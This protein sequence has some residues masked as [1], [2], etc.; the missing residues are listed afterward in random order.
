MTQLLTAAL[1][2]V[3]PSSLGAILA[4]VTLATLVGVHEIDPAKWLTV[5][6]AL[7]V[8]GFSTTKEA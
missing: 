1:N 4:F 6:I 7:L 3:H 5:A 8:P 2:K